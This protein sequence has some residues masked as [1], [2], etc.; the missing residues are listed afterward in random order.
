MARIALSTEPRWTISSFEP[1]KSHDSTGISTPS[2]THTS[3]W[4][5]TFALDQTKPDSFQLFGPY[6]YPAKVAH[7]SPFS[8]T[9]ST[10]LIGGSLKATFD[11]TV[12]PKTPSVGT[13]FGNTET[14]GVSEWC[15]NGR[16]SGTP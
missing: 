16:C 1:K 14:F 5:F 9:K 4:P 13:P 15:I 12:S 6:G 10:A 8:K 2:L 7:R 3:A 11:G